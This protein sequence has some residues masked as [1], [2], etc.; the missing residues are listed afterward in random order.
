MT[1]PS[2]AVVS[3]SLHQSFPSP[4]VAFFCHFSHLSVLYF[5]PL[6]L[7]LLHSYNSPG[8]RPGT[9]SPSTFPPSSYVYWQTPIV[10][11]TVIKAVL[12]RWLLCKAVMTQAYKGP[13][14]QAAVTFHCCTLWHSLQLPLLH[15]FAPCF[16]VLNGGGW[17]GEYN[18]GK[19]GG[20][21]CEMYLFINSVCFPPCRRMLLLAATLWQH[22]L[23]PGSSAS[24]YDSTDDE[25]MFES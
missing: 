2:L 23:P 16:C 13:D 8:I 17:G 11:V 18:M 20:W 9:L 15:S 22:V 19:K 4:S 6:S 24:L 12:V 10:I 21:W 14:I 3:G 5:N 1:S 7:L 25:W